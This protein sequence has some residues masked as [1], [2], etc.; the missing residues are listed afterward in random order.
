MTITNANSR[1]LSSFRSDVPVMT[2]VLDGW[3][4]PTE[5]SLIVKSI[6]DFRTVETIT[7]RTVSAVVQPFTSKQLSIKPEG[8]RGWSWKTLHVKWP[9]SFNL[10]DVI[11]IDGER[12]R[13]DKKTEWNEYG[14]FQ[15]EICQDYTP[16]AVVASIDEISSVEDSKDNSSVIGDQIAAYEA[17]SLAIS[18]SMSDSINASET[19]TE[20]VS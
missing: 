14:Y 12:Y 19:T 11:A 4:R 3:M 10:D 8:E 1:P 16:P 20:V 2:E 18:L 17:V 9:D 5:V 15:Y 7:L 6:V 13:V